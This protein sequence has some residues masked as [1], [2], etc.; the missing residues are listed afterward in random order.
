MLSERTNVFK[1]ST[2]FTHWNWFFHFIVLIKYS[3]EDINYLKFVVLFFYEF[4]Y[5]F[6]F[7]NLWASLREKIIY[8]L[9]KEKWTF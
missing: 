5:D 7:L 1:M 8:V 9:F 3:K 4:R 6:I 2:N